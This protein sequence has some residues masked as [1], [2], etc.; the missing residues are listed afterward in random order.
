MEVEI[1]K[2]F[3]YNP[4]NKKPLLKETLKNS[5]FPG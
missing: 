4:A 3:Q 5:E 2:E 1:L